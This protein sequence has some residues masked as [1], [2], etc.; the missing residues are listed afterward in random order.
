MDTKI[1]FSG[2]EPSINF[3]DLDRNNKA[4]RMALFGIMKAFNIGTNEN[5]II[6]GC[7]AT[8]DTGVDVDVTA[9]Y[10]FLNGEILEVEAQT[11]LN[12]GTIDVYKYVKSTTYDAGGDKTFNDSVLRQT[13]QKN[14]GIVTAATT[15]I[16]TTELDVV[17]GDRL[18]DKIRQY[19]RKVIDI[20]NWN[21]DSTSSVTVAHGLDYDSIQRVT[22]TIQ[23]DPIA[24]LFKGPIEYVDETTGLSAGSVYVDET[25]VYLSRVTGAIFDSTSF[26]DGVY[27]RGWII[28]DYLP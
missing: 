10:I 7:V 12:G 25:L 3:D 17:R 8:V 9:G 24:L 1:T 19:G 13:W 18:N 11:V 21:M 5:F 22:A 15:P 26:D 2:G 6:S 28:I 4:N 27:N 14:R 23:S 20:G 16:L